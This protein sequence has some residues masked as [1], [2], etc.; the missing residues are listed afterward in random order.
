[1]SRTPKPSVFLHRANYRQR[2]LRDAAKLVPFIGI[3][4]WSI[5]LMWQSDPAGGSM[6][7]AGLVYIFG[8][9]V[10]LIVLTAVLATRVRA[11][12][13]A[14]DKDAPDR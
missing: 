9:W 11:D 5:P 7:S 8:V 1:M 4:L 13:V 14:D 12:P 2:R 10:F 3:L 6:G